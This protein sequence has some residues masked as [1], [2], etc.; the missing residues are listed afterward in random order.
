MPEERTYR[1]HCPGCGCHV[2]I[3]TE[4]EGR[5]TVGF[6]LCLDAEKEASP[7]GEGDVQSGGVSA[8]LYETVHAQTSRR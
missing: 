6:V 8:R 5:V 1:T 7:E 2:E 3:I 4:T